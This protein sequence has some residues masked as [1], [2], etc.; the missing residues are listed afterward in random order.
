MPPCLSINE[1][2]GIDQQQHGSFSMFQEYFIQIQGYKE[3]DKKKLYEKLCN[4]WQM[5][6]G[7]FWARSGN[8]EPSHHCFERISNNVLLTVEKER[9]FNCRADGIVDSS[10]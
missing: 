9:G 8:V 6:V 10:T 3:E 5:T 4:K 1:N 7:I 2:N